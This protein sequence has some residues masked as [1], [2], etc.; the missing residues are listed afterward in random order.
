MVSGSAPGDFD[1]Q[2]VSGL[3]HETLKGISDVVNHFDAR[4]IIGFVNP[5]CL[6]TLCPAVTLISLSF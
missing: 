4:L 1:L 6:R 2:N 5:G 3:T